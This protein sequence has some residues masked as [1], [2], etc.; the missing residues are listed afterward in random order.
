[1]DLGGMSIRRDIIVKIVSI[2]L[3]VPSLFILE[4]WNRNDPKLLSKQIVIENSD[5]AFNPD[6]VT[7]HNVA[8]IIYYSGKCIVCLILIWNNRL[9]WLKR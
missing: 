8:K 9:T 1:M 3:R 7:K 4:A 2:T 5:Y 6:E